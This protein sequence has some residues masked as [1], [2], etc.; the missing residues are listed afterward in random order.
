[1]GKLGVLGPSFTK[2]EDEMRS[3]DE[4]TVHRE[5]IRGPPNLFS[6]LKWVGPQVRV[7]A[8][9]TC[10]SGFALPAPFVSSYAHILQLNKALSEPKCLKIS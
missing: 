6:H 1:M 9:L 8:K 3:W 2:T 4:N 7:S 10:S 5:K